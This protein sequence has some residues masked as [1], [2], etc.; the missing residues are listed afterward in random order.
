MV[1]KVVA[2]LVTAFAVALLLGG[3]ARVLMRLVTV[4]AGH[5]PGFSWPGTA[6]ILAVFFVAAL[7]G[8]LA[9]AFVRRRRW[10]GLAVGSAL[11]CIPATGVASEELGD[12]T[13]LTWAQWLGVGSASLALYATVLALP[14]VALAL[15]DRLSSRDAGGRAPTRTDALVS[16]L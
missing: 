14:V 3:V 6:G 11:L 7:P 13:T 10:M 2:A 12:T 9:A 15:L 1:R 4:A 16:E 5:V 8:T